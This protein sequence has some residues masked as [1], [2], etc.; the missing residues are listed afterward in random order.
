MRSSKVLKFGSSK[1]GCAVLA[2]FVGVV[3]VEAQSPTALKTL[4]QTQAALGFTDYSWDGDSVCL[5]NA[6]HVVRFF[7]GRRRSEIDDTVVWLNAVAEGNVKSGEWR[8]AAIDLDFLALSILPGDCGAIKPLRVMVDAG[9]GGMDDGAI[10]R[11]PAVAEKALT[12]DTSRRLTNALRQRGFKVVNT[13]KGDYFVPLQNRVNVSNRI[14]RSDAVFVSVHYN[15]AKRPGANGVEVFYNNSPVAQR[16]AVEVA[17][18]LN[19]VMPSDEFRGAKL[20]R[21]T[22]EIP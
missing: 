3:A 10:S 7:Q 19:A 20:G 11:K 13:R 22:L 21:I 15:W 4:A 14:R 8:I 1:V 2:A 17:N 9:H 6:S 16:M 5:S 12:L 18:K